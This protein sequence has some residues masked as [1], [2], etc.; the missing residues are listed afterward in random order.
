MLNSK[1]Y[2]VYYFYNM[3]NNKQDSETNENINADEYKNMIKSWLDADEKINSLT[4]AL[5]DLKDEKK[6]F[7]NYIIDYMEE[8][9]NI[10]EISI[11]DGKIKKSILKSKGGINEK[12]ISAGLSEVTKD[13]TKVKDIIKVICQK[14][15][16]K[17]KTFLKKCKK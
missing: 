16:I 2:F 5:K 4:K 1:L 9:N 10:L 17:E 14:R 11:L 8:H 15:E 7:E 6:Q 3:D 12:V 13:A